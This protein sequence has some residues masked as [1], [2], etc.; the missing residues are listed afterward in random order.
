MI[1]CYFLIQLLKRIMTTYDDVETFTKGSRNTAKAIISKVK[2]KT[3]YDARNKMPVQ[4]KEKYRNAIF[5]QLDNF[6]LESESF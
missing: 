5:S 2:S 3:K 6:D 1:K 4:K